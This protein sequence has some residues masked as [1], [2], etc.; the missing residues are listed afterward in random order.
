MYVNRAVLRVC[1]LGRW[2]DALLLDVCLLDACLLI[3]LSA[4]AGVFGYLGTRY[5]GGE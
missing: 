1:L 5:L 2:P 3:A 4:F